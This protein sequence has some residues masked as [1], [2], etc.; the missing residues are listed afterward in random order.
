M[1]DK[2]HLKILVKNY[3]RRENLISTVRHLYLLELLPE[4][5]DEYLLPPITENALRAGLLD[6]DWK[7]TEIGKEVLAFVK[8]YMPYLISTRPTEKLD[9][10]NTLFVRNKTVYT[11]LQDFLARG[12]GKKKS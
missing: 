11:S 4:Y 2:P 9:E 3:D 10:T 12:V 5:A 8:E 6:K 7:A 1:L